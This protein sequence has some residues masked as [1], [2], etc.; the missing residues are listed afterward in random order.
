MPIDPRDIPINLRYVI[1]LAEIHGDHASTAHFDEELERHVWYSETLDETSINELA[2]LYREMRKHK[3]GALLRNWYSDNWQELRNSAF[4]MYGILFVFQTLG[5]AGIE[6][7]SDGEIRAEVDDIPGGPGQESQKIVKLLS[8]DEWQS[9]GAYFWDS[10]IAEVPEWRELEYVSIANSLYGDQVIMTTNSPIH[11]GVAIYI[12]GPD[13]S[14]P[15]NDTPGWIENIIYAGPSYE[16]WLARVKKYGDEH[17]IA[18]GGIER[19]LGDRAEEY[20]K[21][22]RKLNPGLKW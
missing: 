15:I 22:Y 4:P 21:I 19:E 5:Q 8:R 1:P 17:S 2:D 3:H 12:H 7:F 10:L 6:P 16:N 11:D 14:G 9:K 20:C 18:P 13:I